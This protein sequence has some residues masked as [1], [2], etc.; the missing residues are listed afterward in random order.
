MDNFNY[1][2]SETILQKGG[3]TVRKVTIKA[4][5][6]HKSVTKYRRGKKISIVRKPLHREHIEQIKMRKFIPGLFSDCCKKTR[7][8]K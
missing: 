7:R 8:N 5:K 2:N 1:Y 3:K 6:G 4:G